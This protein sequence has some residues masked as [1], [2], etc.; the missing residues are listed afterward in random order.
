MFEVSDDSGFL[1]LIT[2]A[3]YES[4]VADDWDFS[5]LRSHFRRQMARRALL[6]WHT[7]LAGIWRVDVRADGGES[8]G[9]REVIGPLR[10]SGGLVLVTNYES[11]TI[12]AQFA[13][14]HLPQSHERD[15]LI[16]IPDGDH[17]C[18]VVQMFDPTTG[19]SAEGESAD[20]VVLLS[21]S[22]RPVREWSEIP[23]ASTN[24]GEP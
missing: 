22:T 14:V 10:V 11:L 23:W 17:T 15:Q 21:I 13:N 24:S 1:A 4:F 19:E 8:G 18:R 3:I 9:F 12:A 5:R 6:I 16:A 2:P 7:G 20:F